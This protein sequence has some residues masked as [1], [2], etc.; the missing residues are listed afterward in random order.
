M[1]SRLRSKLGP[2]K[3][4]RQPEPSLTDALVGDRTLPLTAEQR[5]GLG[6][7]S[8]LA[9]RETADRDEQARARAEAAQKAQKTADD[10]WAAHLQQQGRDRALQAGWSA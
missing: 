10:R 6:V 4:E 8:A 1:T 2:R 5:S 7:L 3:I 9:A